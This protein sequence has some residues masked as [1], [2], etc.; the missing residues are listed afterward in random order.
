MGAY[1]RVL[2]RFVGSGRVVDRRTGD[3]SYSSDGVNRASNI[4]AAVIASALPVLAI[5]ALNEIGS[6][7]VRIGVTAAF[8]VVFA[9]LMGIF[10]SAKRSEIIAA[11]AT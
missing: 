5:Y 1:D 4:V 10:S 3:K 9:V 6:T 11:T 8:T 7:Q 2:G